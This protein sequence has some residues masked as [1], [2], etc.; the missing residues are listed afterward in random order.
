VR[1]ADY[2]RGRQTDLHALPE[3]YTLRRAIDADLD[4]VVRLVDEADREIV[5]HVV[6]FAGDGNV[7]I[8]GVVPRWRGRGIAKALLRRAFADWRSEVTRR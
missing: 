5:G 2:A 6:S 7:G 4:A 3:G 1:W 8:L